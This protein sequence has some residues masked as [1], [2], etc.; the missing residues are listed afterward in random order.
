MKRFAWLLAALLAG[1]GCVSLPHLVW[2]DPPP[3]KK[4]VETPPPPIVLPEDVTERNCVQKANDLAKEVDYD[5]THLPTVPV[6]HQVDG[7]K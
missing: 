5:D 6:T 7:V 3:K 1:P 4:E 2:D